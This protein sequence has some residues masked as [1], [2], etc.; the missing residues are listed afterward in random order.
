MP[1]LDGHEALRRLKKLGY[2]KPVI[3]L[4]GH[5]SKEIEVQCLAEGFD[6]YLCK[7]FILDS[8][9]GTLAKILSP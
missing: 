9:E 2:Q 3:A 7:D 4:S 6:G 8:L 1:L 5:V